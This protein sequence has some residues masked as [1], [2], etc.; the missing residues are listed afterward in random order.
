MQLFYI[1]DTHRHD[2]IK[3]HWNAEVRSFTKLTYFF[4]KNTQLL[5]KLLQHLL[6]RH[7]N[8]QDNLTKNE[9][10]ERFC[11][12]ISIAIAFPIHSCNLCKLLFRMMFKNILSYCNKRHRAIAS[13]VISKNSTLSRVKRR[14]TLSSFRHAYF[15]LQENV[16]LHSSLKK[17]MYLVKQ[18]HQ[19][20]IILVA[21]CCKINRLY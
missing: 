8:N 15:T 1:F 10:N 14:L 17:L 19:L 9:L 3:I 6:A 18:N 16:A 4:N 13:C 2:T 20:T 21:I 5:Q 7:S 12:C 11:K